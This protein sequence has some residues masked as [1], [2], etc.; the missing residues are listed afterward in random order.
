MS[1]RGMTKV[2]KTFYYLILLF[3][4]L[5]LILSLPAAWV[6]MRVQ[7]QLPELSITGSSGYWWQGTAHEVSIIYRGDTIN[8]SDI[9][10]TFDGLSLF[11]VKPCIIFS[12]L[13]T[14]SRGQGRLCIDLFSKK[15]YFHQ[16]D[17]TLSAVVVADV[18]NVE[19]QGKFQALIRTLILKDNR[20]VGLQGDV[21]WRQAKFYNGEEWL[22]LGILLMA[23]SSE[24]KNKSMTINWLDMENN[25]PFNPIDVDVEM[26][27]TNSQLVHI[28]GTVTPKNM[29]NRSLLDTLELVSHSREGNTYFIK[30][31]FPR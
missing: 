16:L 20:L 1:K 28:V 17:M 21:I 11:V 27:F 19:I 15:I 29:E 18:L 10:W 12:T 2:I 23:V 4:V 22:D 9:S 13:S 6:V 31:Y 8:L 5:I 14:V 25:L 3:I 7:E 30:S 24:T 26:L